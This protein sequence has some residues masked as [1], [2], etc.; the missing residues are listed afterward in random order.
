MIID[1]VADLHGFL[2][3]TKG[4][5]VLIV[6]GDCTAA[7]KI[8]QWRVFFDWF[9]KQNYRKKILIGGN[10]DGF[11]DQSISSEERRL[12][13]IDP[14]DE[15][16][17]NFYEYLLDSGIDFEGVKFWGSPWSLWFHGV[18]P[19]CKHFMISER[20]IEAYFDLIPNDVD[21]LIT[22]TPPYGVLDEVRHGDM[23]RSCGSVSLLTK[24]I[25]TKCKLHLFGHIHEHGGNSSCVNHLGGNILCVNCSYV[26]EH[27]R[28]KNG[29]QRLVRKDIGWELEKPYK[30]CAHKLLS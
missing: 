18:H 25:S 4:G 11:L 3:S 24:L 13:G 20:K 7:D 19:K 27:Y 9:K 10:H 15:D 22:H 23:Y 21:V 14:Y 12:M 29:V 8:D 26:D 6:A 16:P 5:D 1:F 30:G 17:T 28:P 2:P